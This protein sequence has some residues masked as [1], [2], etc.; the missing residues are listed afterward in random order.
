MTL[1]TPVELGCIS[2]AFEKWVTDSAAVEVE[3]SEGVVGQVINISFF[4]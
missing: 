2:K 3:G 1:S 4:P